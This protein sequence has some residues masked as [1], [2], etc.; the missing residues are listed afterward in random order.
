MRK[1]RIGAALVAG[2][3]MMLA[4][5]LSAQQRQ[6]APDSNLNAEDQLSPS[7]MQQPM[8]GA[9]AAP[10]G[11]PGHAPAKHT[12]TAGS[13]AAAAVRSNAAIAASRVVACS[14]PFSKDSSNLKLAMVFDSR[15]VTFEDVD[16]GGTKVGA[17]VLF[18]K[19]AE[20]PPRNLVGQPGEPQRHLSHPDQQTIDLER[21]G[22]A[23]ARDDAR[24]AGKAQSQAV[25]AERF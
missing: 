16:V 1:Y 23:E 2:F 8:P 6:Q 4:S 20:A 18:P 22:R 11:A 9:V 25:Q 7:Q 3:A 10:G 21:T 17:S 5:P 15:N 19:D 24:G 14:G 12:A 13:P